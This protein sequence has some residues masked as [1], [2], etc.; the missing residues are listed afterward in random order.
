MLLHLL[1]DLFFNPQKGRVT[2][3]IP[4]HPKPKFTPNPI[5]RCVVVTQ[6]LQ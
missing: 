5:H 3:T 4:F 6:V 2:R 1:P